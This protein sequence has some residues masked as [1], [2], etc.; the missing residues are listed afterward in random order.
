MSGGMSPDKI[1][2]GLGMMGGPSANPQ[3]GGQGMN[4]N[5]PPPQAPAGTAMNP[6]EGFRKAAPPPPAQGKPAMGGGNYQP[7]QPYGNPVG[8]AVDPK[9]KAGGK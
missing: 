7:M 9:K 1:K 2:E 3:I 4:P 8:Q 5:G 6:M